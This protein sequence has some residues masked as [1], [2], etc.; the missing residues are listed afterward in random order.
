MKGERFKFD[1]FPSTWRPLLFFEKATKM[2][3]SQRGFS[4]HRPPNLP[5]RTCMKG[6]HLP[7]IFASSISPSPPPPRA[8]THTH[9]SAH[10]TA[11][12]D[13]FVPLDSSSRC[14][15]VY[16]LADRICNERSRFHREMY[17]ILRKTSPSNDD[18]LTEHFAQSDTARISTSKRLEISCDR[19][20][21]QF[22][23]RQLATAISQSAISKY[24]A[25]LYELAHI[26]LIIIMHEE[27]IGTESECKYY[28]ILWFFSADLN[29]ITKCRRKYRQIFLS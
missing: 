1:C 16:S 7:L 13:I 17:E 18:K 29:A 21:S 8:R 6:K 24:F 25:H 20:V 5:C 10:T 27:Y 19:A 22:S 14:F 23:Y 26:S 11:A 15:I 9:T 4:Q 12:S 2:L 28:N 3:L